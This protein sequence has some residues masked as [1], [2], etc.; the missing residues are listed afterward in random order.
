M[1]WIQFIICTALLV[2]AAKQL[3]QYGDV[4]AE[5]TGLGRTWM[6]AVMLAAATSLP[7]LVSGTSAV[8]LLD[9]P[10][11]A[12]GAIF[13][14]C[15]FN[16]ALIAI[17]DLIYQPGTIL[18]AVKEGHLLSAGLGILFIGIASTSILLGPLLNGPVVLGVGATSLVLIGLYLISTRLLF[19]FEKRRQIEV[20]AER[21]EQLDYAHIPARK[22]YL[23]FG[24][25]VLAVFGLGLWLA[26]IAEEISATTGL[27]RSF[28][29][30]LFLAVATSLPEVVVSLAA[31]RLGAIDLA[32]GN[33]LG[34]N[35]FNIAILAVLD[36]AYQRGN[37]WASLSP[38]HA[39]AGLIALTMT[40][41][42]VVSL[43]YRASPKTPYRF[44]WDGVALLA[45][46]GFAMILL[47][48]YKA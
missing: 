34:S 11:L 29:G 46:Y 47:F 9:A 1:V 32:V 14:S 22:A 48:V 3:S 27:A 20:Q 15:L 13:G 24:L 40:G 16:L 25:S 45:M 41:V 10:N 37:L 28:V 17:M 7:E 8:V 21:A 2:L 19:R 31:V 42:V 35:L 30:N 43:I 36:I 4:L 38:V 33:V 44:N 6:G 12:V 26:S 18:S 39:L 23:I 5:K